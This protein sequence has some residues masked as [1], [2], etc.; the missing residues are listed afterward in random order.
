MDQDVA[1]TTEEAYRAALAS[2][3]G[4]DLWDVPPF[5][6]LAYEVQYAAWLAGRNLSVFAMAGMQPPPGYWLARVPGDP[7][8]YAVHTLVMVGAQCAHDPHPEQKLRP[9]GMETT[10]TMCELLLPIDPAL[11]S[12]IHA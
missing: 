9:R 4:M 11:P 1:A 6:G 12:G 8:G 3:L 2:I 10:V 5:P 7:Y